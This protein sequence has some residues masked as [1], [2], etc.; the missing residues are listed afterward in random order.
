MRNHGGG[1][2][3]LVLGATSPVA[4]ALALCFAREGATLYLAA[5]DQSEAARIAQDITVRT[6]A[7]AQAGSFQATDYA[8]HPTVIRGAR[9][10]MGCLDG[11]IV[12]FGMLGDETVAQ[13]DAAHAVAVIE[14]NFTSAASILTVAADHFDGQ[15]TGFIIVIGSVAGDRGRARNYVYGS[16][17]GAL[18]LFCQGLRARFARS[19][20][21]VMTVIM[22]TV[23]TRMTWGREGTLLLVPP[24][25]AATAIHKAWRRK[26]EVVYVPGFWR[27]IMGGLKL[28]PERYFKRLRF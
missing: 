28:I 27:L 5:R 12:A 7:A 16:A 22:G 4:R 1:P 18:A 13:H 23:D 10:A 14:Q 6:G 24:E 11:V 21:H 26:A 20:V 2:G 3:V 15:Q 19:G 9:E 17:K 8:S 25:R